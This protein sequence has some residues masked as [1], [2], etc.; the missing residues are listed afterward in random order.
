[1]CVNTKYNG[2]CKYKLEDNLT[3]TSHLFN[4]TVAGVPLLEPI[5]YV[6]TRFCSHTQYEVPSFGRVLI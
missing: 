3:G 1:M 2:E 4:A 5:A 6:A